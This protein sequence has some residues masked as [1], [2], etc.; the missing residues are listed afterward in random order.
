MSDIDAEWDAFCDDDEIEEEETNIKEIN[1]NE[2]N[3]IAPE[4]TD[5]Y[6]S[7]R[8]EIAFL[9]KEIDLKEF[10]LIPVQN[11]DDMQE[12]NKKTNEIYIHKRRRI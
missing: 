6:I 11:Y 3:E 12:G 5:I 4:P 2:I 9:D 7:T 10:W 8:T 1:E